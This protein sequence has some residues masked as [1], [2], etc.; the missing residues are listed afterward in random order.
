MIKEI[1]IEIKNVG[2][3]EDKMFIEAE[4]EVLDGVD[5]ISVNE[6]NGNCHIKFQDDKISAE[7]ITKKISEIG[8]EITSEKK[9]SS[10]IKEHIYNVSGMHCASCE[11]LIEKKLLQLP[12]VKSVEASTN[13][14]QVVIEYDGTR[15]NPHKLNKIFGEEHY[16]FFDKS[17][18]YNSVKIADNFKNYLSNIFTTFNTSPDA[19]LLHTLTFFI[20][21]FSKHSPKL[22]SNKHL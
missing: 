22:F 13:N 2:S 4:V 20:L 14:G 10:V 19:L 3:A 6:K 5:A 18:D 16:T 17:K 12:E 15:P 21:F 8:F 11:I 1:K 9:K 7:E